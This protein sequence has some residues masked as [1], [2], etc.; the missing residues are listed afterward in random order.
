MPVICF[1]FACCCASM[2][3]ETSQTQFNPLPC[4][5]PIKSQKGGRLNRRCCRAPDSHPAPSSVSFGAPFRN[6]RQ[7]CTSHKAK[8]QHHQGLG[9]RNW[10][11]PGSST[12]EYRVASS[13]ETCSRAALSPSDAA[14]WYL[15]RAVAV[16]LGTPKPPSYMAPSASSYKY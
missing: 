12:I 7:P 11:I 3:L 5:T 10:R 14:F 4:G 15:D 2:S 8:E 1:L 6:R 13:S 16:L 9:P